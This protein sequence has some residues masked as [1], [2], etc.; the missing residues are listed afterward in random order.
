MKMNPD[1]EQD[2]GH[3]KR[4]LKS[5]HELLRQQ[6]ENA[7][8]LLAATKARRKQ[9][10]RQLASVMDEWGY[11]DPIYRYYHHSFKVYRLQFVTLNIRDVLRSL[12]PD[13]PLN[14]LF[15]E[16][17]SAGTGIEF[18][19]SHNREWFLRVTPITT[20]FFHAKFFLEMAVRCSMRYEKVENPLGS[21][22]A[23]LL[24]LFNLR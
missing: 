15:E 12:L 3:P 4:N 18:E 14:K 22:L 11:C 17:I 19:E 6:E 7:E 8:R 1:D 16:V 23:A 13:L 9:L 20:A 21:D 10:T 2:L 5:L 24:Y